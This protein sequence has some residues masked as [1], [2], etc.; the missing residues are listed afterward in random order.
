VEVVAPAFRRRELEVE[1]RF[2]E[3]PAP[4]TQ[5]R[6]EEDHEAFARA[7][8]QPAAP[9][10]FAR[11]FA[12]PRRARITA[13]FGEERTL[14]STKASQHYGTDLAGRVGDRVA[15]ANDGEVVLVRDCFASGL[16]VIVWHGAGIYSAYFH[17]SRAAVREGARVRRGERV[18]AVGRSGRVT[19]P[20]LH[21][22]MK[23]GEL[24]VDPESVLRLP[25]SRLLRPAP[26]TITAQ[27]RAPR[28]APR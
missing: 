15:A 27:P 7:F 11:D 17:L 8:S 2:V 20:H 16:T 10:L 21:W 26:R 14:N 23:V 18:G 24:Y 25:F 9:P 6:I 5:R 12:L 19:G 13:R 28:R 22:S 4:E 3:P 1:P